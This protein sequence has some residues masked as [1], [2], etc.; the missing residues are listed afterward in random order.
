MSTPQRRISLD[1]LERANA[2]L[3]RF[4]AL[5]EGID[6]EHPHYDVFHAALVKGFEFTYG[7]A[8]AALSRYVANYVLTPGQVGQMLLPDVIRTAAAHGVIGP[9]EQWFDFRE[10]RNET[11]HEYF[12]DD[13]AD[14]IV[15][16]APSLH[17]AV[18]QLLDE[19]RRRME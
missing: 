16:T 11:A 17:L 6:A 9:P 10:R 13:T 2:C 5:Y 19:L 4:V 3:G 14:R 7:L 1:A 8:I 15:S 12:D 18:T